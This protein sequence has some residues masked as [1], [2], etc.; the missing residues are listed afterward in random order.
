MLLQGTGD[1][2]DGSNIPGASKGNIE[3]GGATGLGLGTVLQD[4]R[5]TYLEMFGGTGKER[6]QAAKLFDAQL[7]AIADGN[8]GDE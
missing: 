5:E 8:C 3:G 6:D 2:L 1:L 4:L 7:R